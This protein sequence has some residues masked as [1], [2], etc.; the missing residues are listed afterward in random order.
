MELTTQDIKMKPASDR[1]LSACKINWFWAALS[2]LLILIFS[3]K[4]WGMERA[5]VDFIY[6]SFSGE[7]YVAGTVTFPPGLV[8]TAQNILVEKDGQGEVPIKLTV[9]ESWPDGSILNGEVIFVA[10]TSKQASYL[11]CY[12][13]DVKG[14]KRMEKTAVLPTIAF[15]IGGAPRT[16]ENVNM[17]VGTLNV[18]VDRSPPLHYYWHII[19]ITVI[20]ILLI[21]RARRAGKALS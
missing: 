9:Q 16:E 1:S 7:F 14:S 4:S 15:S 3:P 17:D 2:M 8:K 21:I 12:G 20:I 11:L 10:S 18:T 13:D 6:P 19:P 5:A